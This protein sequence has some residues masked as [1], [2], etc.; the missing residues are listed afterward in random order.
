[1]FLLLAAALVVL[2]S[3]VLIYPFLRGRFQS[4]DGERV[5]VP[6]MG[7]VED[8][9]D[10]IRTLH[11]EYQLGNVPEEQ[12]REELQAYRVQAA[13]MLRDRMELPT[14]AAAM[15]LEREVSMARLSAEE[16][17]PSPG[18]TDSTTDSDR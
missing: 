17:G 10:A 3:G 2:S 5:P 11:L 13:A 14:Q 8:I 12:Y 4:E 16:T 6:V 9:L 15:E 7:G 18:E 1:M